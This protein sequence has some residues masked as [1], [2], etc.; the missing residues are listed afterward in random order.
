M[1]FEVTVLTDKGIP[2]RFE[3]LEE[4]GYPVHIL[5]SSAKVD[6]QAHDSEIDQKSNSIFLGRIL[7]NNE[8]RALLSHAFIIKES[9]ND[10]LV[11]LEDDAILNKQLFSNFLSEIGNLHLS[12][13]TILLLYHGK[14]GVFVRKKR[15]LIDGSSLSFHRC[16][17]LP[18]GAVSYAINLAAVKIVQN[19]RKYVGTADWPTW[20]ANIDFYGVFPQLAF[21]DYSVKSIAQL[22]VKLN[23]ETSWPVERYKFFKM[24]GSVFNSSQIEAYGGLHNYLKLNIFAALFRRVSLYLP[25]FFIRT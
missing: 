15:T 7:S 17:A 1:S 16:L 13:P 6:F 21:H 11:V 24:V 10:W 3:L 5:D 12:A 8:K 2:R 20:S 14:N 9:S 22:D 23:N 18:S 4:I 19:C 25:K